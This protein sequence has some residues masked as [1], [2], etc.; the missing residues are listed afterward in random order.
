MTVYQN[1]VNNINL[2]YRD[3]VLPYYTDTDKIRVMK[4]EISMSGFPL[5]EAN[6]TDELDIGVGASYIGGADLSAADTWLYVYVYNDS[7]NRWAA[8][9]YDEPPLYPTTIE[10]TVFDAQLDAN[11]AANAVILSYDNDTG[12]NDV[13]PGDILRGWTDITFSTVRGGWTVISIDTVGNNIT[14]EVNDVDA[15]DNDYLTIVH[16]VPRYRKVNGTWYRCVGAIRLN[17]STQIMKF[18]R[19]M[20]GFVSHDARDPVII[21]AAGSSVAWT[22]VA[23]SN[24]IP[25]YSL[26][27]FLLLFADFPPAAAVNQALVYVKPIESPDLTGLLFAVGGF[28]TTSSGFLPLSPNQ[29]LMYKVL[30]ASCDAYLYAIGYIEEL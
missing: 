1:A 7:D 9:L 27:S 23:A 26:R 28:Q 25:P 18:Q 4:G 30:N 11:P 22:R 29:A 21:L 20:C 14:V 13:E 3:G 2:H 12:E 8:L 10:T 5:T 19:N 24:Y 15:A 17:A 16:G 6:D